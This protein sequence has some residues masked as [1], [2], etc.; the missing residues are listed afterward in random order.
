MIL[1]ENNM[2]FT[3]QY[4]ENYDCR[5]PIQ[6][7][8]LELKL[9]G[10]LETEYGKAALEYIKQTYSICNNDINAVRNLHKNIV[11]LVDQ[12]PLSP[13]L[14]EE[15]VMTETLEYSNGTYVKS[16]RK[17]HP[18]VPFVYE[19]DGKYY[20]DRAICFVN[21]DGSAWYGQNGRHR[22]MR[23]ITFPYYRKEVRQYIGEID[24]STPGNYTE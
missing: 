5:D 12:N 4:P 22:S 24:T 21:N 19:R 1:Q 14:E 8:E 13:L 20:D 6:F 11:G 3:E 2:S 9:S 17:Q 7:A 10:F 23:E 15:L 18:R 16:F